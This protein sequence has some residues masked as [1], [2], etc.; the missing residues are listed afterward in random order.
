MTLLYAQ[1]QFYMVGDCGL[2]A[3][4]GAA[5]DPEINHKVLAAKY[6]LEQETPAGVL[7]LV[8]AYCSLLIVYHPLT[9]TSAALE[10]IL[11]DLEDR[12]TRIEVPAPETVEVPVCYGDIYG[13]D[14]QRVATINGLSEEKVIQ[15]HSE[16]RYPIY[17]LGFTPG[18]PFLGGLSEALHTPR[19]D[20]PRP[21]VPAGS[22]GIANNQ[23]GIY[24]IDSPGG[25][26]LIGQTPLR[27]FDARQPSP[28]LLKAGNLLKFNPISAE[29]FSRLAEEEV[30]AE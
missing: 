19:L 27:L 9:T 3:V 14:I 5:I 6:A 17:M 18:F 12:L 7:E 29:A 1:P 15:L 20:S 4:Y 16:P 13:P 11:L 24:P 26:Q 21:L 2:L 22:V 28:F 25:W 23:T 8:P 10:R 30:A